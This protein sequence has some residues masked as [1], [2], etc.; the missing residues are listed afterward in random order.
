LIR[1][2]HEAEGLRLWCDGEESEG[3]AFGVSAEEAL[4]DSVRGGS[5]SSEKTDLMKF[6]R[7]GEKKR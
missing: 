4:L 6:M 1:F 2:F 5:D 3:G 7:N